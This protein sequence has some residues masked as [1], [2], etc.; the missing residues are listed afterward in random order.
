[1][2][3]EVGTRFEAF[4]KGESHGKCNGVIVVRFRDDAVGEVTRLFHL[5][6]LGPRNDDDRHGTGFTHGFNVLFQVLAEGA[7]AFFVD[8]FGRHPLEEHDV[9][10]LRRILFDVGIHLVIRQ[11]VLH[12]V[13]GEDPG[14]NRLQ[15]GFPGGLRFAGEAADVTVNAA[16]IERVGITDEE[17]GGG[18][19]NAEFGNERL[20]A[21]FK[22]ASRCGCGR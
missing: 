1:M 15:T 11:V 8:G 19:R 18:I 21:R 14:R 20:Y 13:P 6:L 7:D 17:A 5:V 10:H 3:N 16:V 12:V 22:G 2:Q 9:K 4:R